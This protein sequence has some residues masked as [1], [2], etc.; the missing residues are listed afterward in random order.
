MV[1]REIWAHLLGYNLIR[2]VAAQA[3]LAKNR[4]PR[5]V[6]FT[7]TMQTIFAAWYPLTTSSPAQCVS[8]AQQLFAAIRGHVVGNRP[9]RCEPRRVKPRRQRY[10]H[11]QKPRAELRA[12]LMTAV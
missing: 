11:L 8:L 6:S 5:Q 7:G 12:E 10:P 9:G 2:K 4:R 1:H 3:A